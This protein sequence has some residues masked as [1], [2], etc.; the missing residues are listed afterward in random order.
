MCPRPRVLTGQ[1][2][3]RMKK[4]TASPACQLHTA[5]SS[6]DHL[7]SIISKENRKLGAS[8]PGGVEAGTEVPLA[9]AGAGPGV[10]VHSFL[11]LRLSTPWARAHGGFSG[12]ASLTYLGPGWKDCVGDDQSPCLA[13]SPRAYLSSQAGP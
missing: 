12:E 2:T 4:N 3:V 9:E 11:D 6:P 1:W 10:P 8:K 13:H 7:P 5:G